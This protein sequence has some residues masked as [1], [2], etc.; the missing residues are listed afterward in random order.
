MKPPI[1]YIIIYFLCLSTY[2]QAQNNVSF[3]EEHIDFQL[4]SKYFTINGIYSFYNNSNSLVNQQIIFPF[5]DK[6]TEI[7]SIRVLNLN[8]PK[9]T[10]FIR[11]EN[12]ISFD[13]NIA[14]KDTVDINIF[15]RQRIAVENKYIIT[16]TQTWGK[17]LDKAVYTLTA[18]KN[19]RIK[20]FSYPYN[21]VRQVK[22]KKLYTWEMREFMP[23]FDFEITI[24]TSAARRL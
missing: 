16:S 15:Y 8:T 2:I 7:D 1:V 10:R 12:S 17:P 21:S 24:D 14:A 18:D 6:T 19:L 11:L 4:D 23:K 3:F 5:A 9:S 20:S 22:D 13:L